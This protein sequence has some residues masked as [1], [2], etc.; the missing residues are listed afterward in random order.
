VNK[1]KLIIAIDGHSSC[2]KS[3]L[4]KALSDYFSYKFID[5]GAMYRAVTL[6]VIQYNL[7]DS[8]N[9]INETEL[10]KAF[11][12]N[13]INID[14]RFIDRKKI[15]ET[16][17]NN[18][19]IETEIRGVEVS[20][21]VSPVAKIDFVREKLVEQQRKMGQ[22]GGIVMDGRDI[23]TV[24]FPNADL[25]IFLTARPDV[26]AKRRYDELISKGMKVTYNEIFKNI[27][28]RDFI[29]SNR[30]EAPLRKAD[31]AVLIDNSDITREEQLKIAVD[32]INGKINIK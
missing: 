19:N 29:D 27:E 32:L 26:R 21:L 24:V 20:Q 28:E 7:I 25:K 16:F 17:L 23:G 14:F 11:E 5:T 18:V 15:S 12:Q 2:G 6:Y 31:D 3:T 9:Q 10:R 22:S 4:A 13:L 1:K 30:D 8:E